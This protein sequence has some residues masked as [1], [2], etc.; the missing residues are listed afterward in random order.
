MRFTKI[1]SVCLGGIF[2]VGLSLNVGSN[3]IGAANAFQNGTM[4]VADGGAPL[5]PPVL[6]ADG[7]A[8][9]PPPVLEADGGAPLPPPILVADG[10]APLPPPAIEIATSV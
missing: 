6:V 1:L 7:G 10:G 2:V 9:L 8:P 3:A 4:L 5:P